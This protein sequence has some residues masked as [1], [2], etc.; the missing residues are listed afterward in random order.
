MQTVTLPDGR[1]AT[2]SFAH[3]RIRQP[4]GSPAPEAWGGITIC[5]LRIDGELLGAIFG[6]SLCSPLDNFDRGRGRRIALARAAG[7]AVSHD[8]TFAARDRL[9]DAI[10]GKPA[11]TWLNAGY[12]FIMRD[13]K[14]REW[15][16]VRWSTRK[17]EFI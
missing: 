7:C 2:A 17:V 13:P 12:E 15:R 8:F 14:T 10:I 16:P 5:S 11:A 4:Q 3:L 6:V 1:Q 9:P